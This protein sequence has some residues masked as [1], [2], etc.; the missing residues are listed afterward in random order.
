[1]IAKRNPR[2]APGARKSTWA[3]DHLKDNADARIQSPSADDIY[4]TAVI[5]AATDLGYTVSIPCVVC[6][7]PLTHPKSVAAHVGPKCSRKAVHHG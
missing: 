5:E 4:E 2:R 6:G 7:H 1:M 3:A